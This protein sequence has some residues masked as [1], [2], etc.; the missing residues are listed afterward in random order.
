MKISLPSL[1]CTIRDTIVCSIRETDE[2][3]G[4]MQTS[5]ELPLW[6]VLHHPDHLVQL[7]DDGYDG[8]G[9][10]QRTSLE[11]VADVDL[12]PWLQ[13]GQLSKHASVPSVLVLVLRASTHGSTAQPNHCDIPK[14]EQE[15]SGCRTK[16]QSQSLACRPSH[17]WNSMCR[18]KHCKHDR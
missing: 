14:H 11:V 9:W 7:F 6:F 4:S 13:P 3:R 2:S 8:I 16:L 15:L 17:A 12:R 1:W 5:I 18:V 10:G